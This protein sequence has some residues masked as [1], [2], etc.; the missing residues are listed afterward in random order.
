MS[1]QSRIAR[2]IAPLSHLPPFLRARA[3]TALF[4]RF[5]PF[6]GT[7]GVV[8]EE[9]SLER[10]ALRLANKRRVQN[11]IRGVHAAAAALLAETATG[12][13]VGM[14]LP[15]DKL[16]LLRSMK[17]NYTRRAHGDLSAVATLTPEQ[18]QALLDQ[19]KGDVPVAVTVTDAR[20]ES[21]MECEF[22]WAW[23]TKKP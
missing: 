12:F 7:A 8:F 1:R 6:T 16:P 3:Q 20:G 14:N 11:H 9:V 23:V 21:P 17:V 18:R 15:D 5:V 2:T 22:V 4:H 10:V 19:P 13:V